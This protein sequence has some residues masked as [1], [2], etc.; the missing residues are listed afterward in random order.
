MDKQSAISKQR[1]TLARLIG[2]EPG[3]L[4][5]AGAADKL[6]QKGVIVSLH[7]GR[8]RAHRALGLD[9][10]G[11]NEKQESD[12][13][14]LGQKYLLPTDITKKLQSIE[15]A[16][17]NFITVRSI[18]TAFGAF[19][20]VDAFEPFK[21]DL[22]SYRDSYFAVRD[23]IVEQYDDIKAKLLREYREIARVAYTRQQK[24]AG[25]SYTAQGVAAYVE[26]FVG[27]IESLIPTKPEIEAS[28]KFEVKLSYIPLL[29]M[30]K[31]DDDNATL[32]ETLGQ[33][34]DGFENG[35]SD[36]L[37]QAAVELR[38]RI[39]G[40]LENVISATDSRGKLHSRSAA[41]LQNLVETVSR[42]NWANDREIKVMLDKIRLVAETKVA[43]ASGLTDAF[44]NILTVA[45]ST[46]IDLGDEPRQSRL[47]DVAD[48]PTVS[49]VRKA[50]GALG[51][52]DVQAV[53]EARG[54][55][56]L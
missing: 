7:V 16:A 15:T 14:S 20:P 39:I 21:R 34:S 46:I 3:E 10:L 43:D 54:K 45:R 28:F 29:S 31:E 9:D 55:R 24:L 56:A 40:T 36:L 38:Q 23:M 6:V 22:D 48:V 2:V 52:S 37:T 19:I 25:D 11:I 42:L 8:W 50:R 5:V 17:R 44:K 35:A 32:V 27:R 13:L 12:L 26:R 30:L 18:P 53:G 1:D 49:A 4:S 41:S 47:S 33:F 51:L